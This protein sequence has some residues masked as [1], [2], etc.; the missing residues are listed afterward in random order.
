MPHHL[1]SR[2]RQRRIT[3]HLACAALALAAFPHAM[4]VK[5]AGVAQE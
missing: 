5:D 3:L 4:V 2:I 1:L